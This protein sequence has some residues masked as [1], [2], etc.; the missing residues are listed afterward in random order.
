M[1]ENK[2]KED[3]TKIVDLLIQMDSIREAIGELKKDMKSEHEMA[4]PKITKI[5]TLI[6]KNSLE[7][8]D[9]KWEEIKELVEKCS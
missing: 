6:R 5:A 4:I 9:E 8:E 7:E 3:I 1:N 2:F